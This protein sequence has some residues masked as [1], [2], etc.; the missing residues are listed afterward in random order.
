MENKP[1]L[2]KFKESLTTPLKK[3]TLCFLV[4]DTQVLLAMKKRG[5]AQGKWNGTGGKME[6]KDNSIK[7][8][9]IRETNEEISVTPTSLKFAATLNFYHLGNP[10]GGQQVTVFLSDKWKGEPTESEEMAPM[11]FEYDE[12]PYDQMWE[13]DKHWLPRVLNNERIEGD[14]LFDKNQALI[15]QDIRNAKGGEIINV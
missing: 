8:T 13:D 2:E 10:E 6:A 14:F 4:R 11:W 1:D 7:E 5:F 9:A 12:L 3:A 15:E